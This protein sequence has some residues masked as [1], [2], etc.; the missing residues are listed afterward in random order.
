MNVMIRPLVEFCVNNLT[1]DVIEAKEVLEQDPN[2]DVI[3]YDCLGH[4]LICAQ[5]PYAMVEGEPI[6][7]TTG[8]E[9]LKNIYQAIEQMEMDD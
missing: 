1:D 2:L 9:L 4:C 5:K 7:G 3:E 8:Q 6:T